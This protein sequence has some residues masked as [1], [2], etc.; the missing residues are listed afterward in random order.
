[1]TKRK[2]LS[3]IFA[4]DIKTSRKCNQLLKLGKDGKAQHLQANGEGWRRFEMVSVK[5]KTSKQVKRLPKNTE[6]P[7]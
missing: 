6:G 4:K 3:S 7:T 2:T 1:M 5:K